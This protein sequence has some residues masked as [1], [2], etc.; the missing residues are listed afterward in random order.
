MA[1]NETMNVQIFY[2][3]PDRIAGKL[4]AIVTGG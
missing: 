2:S 3:I 4:K 1:R